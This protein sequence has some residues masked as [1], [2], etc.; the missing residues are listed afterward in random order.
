MI[1]RGYKKIGEKAI[2]G[3]YLDVILSQIKLF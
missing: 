2:S 1:E 3:T